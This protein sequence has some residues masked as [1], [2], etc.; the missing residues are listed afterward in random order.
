MSKVTALNRFQISRE[1]KLGVDGHPAAA[2]SLA[3]TKYFCPLGG[4][5]DKI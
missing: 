4:E 3:V 1:N 5:E 2:S